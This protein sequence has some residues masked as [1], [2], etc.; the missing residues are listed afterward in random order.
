[1]YGVC[2]FPSSQ[3]DEILFEKVTHPTAFTR[4]A[5]S[6]SSPSECFPPHT[7]CGPEGKQRRWGGWTEGRAPRD[8]WRHSSERSEPATLGVLGW[9]VCVW[10]L[11]VCFF[12]VSSFSCWSCFGRHA[13]TNTKHNQRATQEKRRLGTKSRRHNGFIVIFSIR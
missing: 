10:V 7:D 11:F 13:P 3:R 1:M 4:S 9:G 8:E 6:L 5:E 12:F 2:V